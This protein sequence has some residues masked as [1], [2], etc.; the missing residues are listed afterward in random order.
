VLATNERQ[1]TSR[2][3]AG[4]AE[5]RAPDAFGPARRLTVA[6]LLVMATQAV[7]GLLFADAYRD[8]EW[9]RATW[10]GNDWA[11]LVI[12]TPL[13]ALALVRSGA[14]CVQ[15]LL[16]WLGLVGYSLYN[17]AFYLFGAALN[18]FF[19]IYVAGVVSAGAVLILLLSHIDPRRVAARFRSTTPVRLIGAALVFIAIGLSLVWIAIWAGYVFAGRPTPIE[20]EAF[21]LVAALDLSLM[22]PALMA[23]GVLVWK[24]RRWGFV[25]ATIASI[26]GALY[27]LVLSIN[28]VVLIQRGMSGAPGELPIWGPLTLFT[29]LVALLLLTNIRSERTG[30]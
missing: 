21:K 26:Q 6:L 5:E 13:L 27:L 10:F 12:A 14:G 7:T 30:L 3:F 4:G 8:V 18:A 25:I 16:L 23:G 22:V 20:P 9:V 17:Y 24:R 29:G 28:T 19:P 15:G 2:S 1:S 11:T